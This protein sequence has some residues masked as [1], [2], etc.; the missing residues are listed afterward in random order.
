MFSFLKKKKIKNPDGASSSTAQQQTPSATSSQQ[1]QHQEQLSSSSNNDNKENVLNTSTKP[2]LHFSSDQQSMGFDYSSSSVVSPNSLTKTRT[3]SPTI[4]HQHLSTLHASGD[5]TSKIHIDIGHHPS[6][7]SFLLCDSSQGSP[8]D[9]TDAG[10][11][12]LP[13]H[14]SCLVASTGTTSPSQIAASDLNRILT[15]G[16]INAEENMGYMKRA[17]DH[18][19][20]HTKSPHFHR[21]IGFSYNR[22]QTFSVPGTKKGMKALVT[23]PTKIR[24]IHCSAPSTASPISTQ[25]IASNNKTPGHESTST[26]HQQDV[27]V[28]EEPILLSRYSGGFIPDP[29]APRKIE[30][31]DW[32]API[33]L[34]AV[35]ELM[36]SHRSRSESRTE[37]RSHRSH[38]HSQTTP[39]S[40]PLETNTSLSIHPDQAPTA[41]DITITSEHFDD[42]EDDDEDQT[43]AEIRH[44]VQLEKDIELMSKLK[45][46]SGMAHALLEDLKLK[47]KI[48]S[49]Q[50]PLDPW[51]ASRSP[52]AA[53][54]PPRR[55]RF[56]SPKFASPSRRVHTHSSSTTNPDDSLA[57]LSTSISTTPGGASKRVTLPRYQQQVLRPGYGLT[58]SPKAQTLPTCLDMQRSCD[59]DSTDLGTTQ[60]YYSNDGDHNKSVKTVDVGAGDRSYIEC[61]A[62][63]S[64]RSAPTLMDNPKL[65]TYEE[66]KLMSKK[67]LPMDVDRDRLEHHLSDNEFH[68]LFQMSRSDFYRLPEWRRIDL[69]KRFKL[70]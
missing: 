29:N 7:R 34:Q 42:D 59:L 6:D 30:C 38:H 27:T 18:I 33:A 64:T 15:S 13:P 23:G 67:R 51:K 36:K 52:S 41:D 4:H 69:K 20:S 35:P 31:L 55:C 9:L 60:S 1:V 54:E 22:T 11:S 19:A 65:Y 32:P 26:S 49:K 46:S 58:P 53:V 25:S 10:L 43:D 50:L 56:E 21:P 68:K 5:Q 17:G 3:S 14:K 45:D 44:D 70:F 28:E 16:Y 2:S 47:E 66:L 24:K 37:T 62:A 48:I 8:R 40:P 63:H 12:S 57:G 39:S 61:H